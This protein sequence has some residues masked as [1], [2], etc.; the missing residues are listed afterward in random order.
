MATPTSPGA[1]RLR[2]NPFA[3]VKAGRWGR[4]LS[5]AYG[6]RA[7]IIAGVG[8]ITYAPEAERHRASEFLKMVL[9]VLGYDQN[10]E[11]LVGSSWAVNTLELAKVKGLLKGLGKSFDANAALTRDEAAQIMLNALKAEKVVYGQTVTNLVWNA[12]RTA[13]GPSATPLLLPLLSTFP[14]T[15][16]RTT[17]RMSSSPRTST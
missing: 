8:H 5:S 3:D 13:T 4:E 16:R 7:G 1:L 10:K 11:G 2:S 17:T 9:V 14:R 6:Y 15:A 12:K